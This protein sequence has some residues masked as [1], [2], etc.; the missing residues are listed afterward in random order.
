MF[1]NFSLTEE[2]LKICRSMILVHFNPNEVIVRQGDPG[3][4]FFYIL[5]GLV[6]IV[7]SKKYDILESEQSK[8]TVDKTIGDL[9]PGQG[10]GELSLI[11][12]TPRSATIISVTNSTLF[13]LDKLSFDK[14]VKDV[15]ENQLQDQIDFIKICP[16][17][18]N[19]PK[20]ILIKIA[21]RSE[22]KKFNYNQIILNKDV[23]PEHLY[24][25]RIG[26]VKVLSH[27]IYSV[28]F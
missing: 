15:Y 25:I 5:S 27:K 22:I 28:Y 7:V 19:I 1:E 6:K 3:D 26:T 18:H 20:D 24:I 16:I 10:F 21:I 4:S 9:K 23:K 11:Y 8:V 14:Y 17:F 13:K 2:H 12:G